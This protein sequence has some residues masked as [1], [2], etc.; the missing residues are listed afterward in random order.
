MN[1]AI[2]KL[3][4]TWVDDSILAMQRPNDV[5]MKESNLIEQFKLNGI[6]AVFNLTEPGEHPYCGGGNLKE[7]GFPYHPEKL[8][9]SGSKTPNHSKKCRN[10]IS[11]FDYIDYVLFYVVKHFNYAWPDMTAPSLNLMKDIVRVACNEIIQ[12]GKVSIMYM[13]YMY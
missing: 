9:A 10:I 5:L 6:V 4:S 8:M 7:S 13:D 11:K 1:P 2:D 3:H 12:G